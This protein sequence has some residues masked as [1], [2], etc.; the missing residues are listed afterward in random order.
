MNLRDHEP[1]YHLWNSYYLWHSILILKQKY[2]LKTLIAKSPPLK[3]IHLHPPKIF[4]HALPPTQNNAPLT[5]IN[6]HS[7]KIFPHQT[8]PTQNNVSY[9]PNNPK[10]SS[11]HLH[12]PKIQQTSF[13][14]LF[15]ISYL[16]NHMTLWLW[17]QVTSQ[18]R[19][20]CPCP[21]CVWPPNLV[22]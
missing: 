9:T 13:G 4:S 5:T 17:D 1:T 10:N 20:L 18:T 22:G 12:S 11:S 15:K 6:P 2:V 16:P 14:H 21:Q 8:P 19:N 7:P 3:P